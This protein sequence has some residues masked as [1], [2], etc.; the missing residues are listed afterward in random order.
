MKRKVLALLAALGYSCSVSAQDVQ[1][2]TISETLGEFD[3][4]RVEQPDGVAPLWVMRTEV[5][6]DLYDIF[7]LRLDLPKRERR[8]NVDAEARPSKPYWL[9]DEGF[10][11][12]GHPALAINFNGAQKFAVWLSEKTG[13]QFRLPS[14]EEWEYF[15]EAGGD[16]GGE[17]DDVAWYD[18]NSDLMTGSIGSKAP[19]GFGLLDTLGNVAEWA[20][21][22]DGKMVIKGG[23]YWDVAEDVHCAQREIYT[24]DWNTSDPQFPKSKW[25]MADA[26]FAGFRLVMEDNVTAN[27]G[28]EI[29]VA[30]TGADE[31]EGSQAAPLLTIQAAAERAQPG[32][33]ITVH[34]GIY[35]ERVNPPR[36]GSADDR[37]IVYR[38]AEGEKVAIKGSERIDEW[39][40][41]SDDTWKANIPADFF[42]EFNPFDDLIWGDWFR[43]N[44]RDHHTGAVYLNGHWL[45]E[46]A[47]KEDVLK[48]A[49]EHPLWFASVDEINTT[50]WAQFK[51]IDPNAENVEI[52]VRQSV[53]YPEKPGVNYITVQGFTLEHAATPWAPPTAEQIGLIGTHW[54][55][56]WVIE[57]NTIRYSA[58]S[59]VTLGKYG[60]EFD[61]TS[62]SSARGYVETIERA[63]KDGWSKENIGHHRVLN[64][65]VSYCEQAGIVGS[66]GAAF[67]TI[68]GNEIHDIHMRRLYSG[69]EMGGIKIH[70]AIDTHIIN[71]HVY[72]TWRGIWLDWMAQ[73]ARVSRNL[74]HDNETTQDLFVEVNHGPFLIDHNFF[75][76][77][78]GL[79]DISNGGAYAHN[80][81]A[82]R[83]ITIPLERNTPYHKAHSTEIAG[84][85]SFYSGDTRFYN[86]VFTSQ[87]ER[88][89]WPERVPE[90]LDNQHYFG[91]A[92]YDNSL[93]PVSM[94]G[95][96]FLG[97][98]ESS[99]NEKDP[100]TD[101]G[102]EPGYELMEKEDGWYL[103]LA[104]NSTWLDHK[105]SLVTSGLLGEARISGLPFEQP[106]GKRYKLD[107]DYLGQHHDQLAPGPLAAPRGEDQWH[108]VW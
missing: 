102:I 38:A 6:W 33:V 64:N 27:I 43:S 19:N 25:W 30:K 41:V 1:T 21:G 10:G 2:I 60:D 24:S 88:A 52:N 53:F 22:R 75:L 72:R 15:C 92:P 65:S 8:R 3:V 105:R 40:R 46:A 74:L 32:D 16:R 26:P 36:G 50:L 12:N 103:Q 95:N 89:V 51:G 58:C 28:N 4:V 68:S 93:L 97:Q 54:S 87:K 44:D 69:M 20:V 31:N 100:V 39:E 18:D 37:R 61:N 107:T 62:D 108:K 71:N 70:G 98:A 17:L 81:F 73:G 104:F 82:G 11:H 49:E 57:N 99:A 14:E 23:A 45:T 5:S 85:E 101:P 56:G 63:L 80:L 84:M 47:A 66:M 67:S 55:K 79:Y 86:N 29:H 106:D 13:K 9:P 78:N 42:G 90:A 96:V 48:P 77:G 91:L 83:L 59:C 76:S 34:E 35:R 94:A 7:L